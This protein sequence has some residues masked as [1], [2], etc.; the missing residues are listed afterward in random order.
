MSVKLFVTDLDGTLL[1]GGKTVSP[2]NIRAVREAVRAGVTV[3]I[4]TG[5]MYRAALPVAEALGVEVP[6][7]T[8]NGALI[9]S[10][11]GRVYYR[12]DIQPGTVRRVV[13]FCRKR[14]WHVQTYSRDELYFAEYD[15]YAR[16]YECDQQIR[17]HVVGW[18]GLLEHTEEVSKLLSITD[19]AEQTENRLHELREAFGREVSPV[20]SKAN[21][22][23]IIN[24]GVSKADG[25]RR[26]AETLG[27]AIADTMAIG[28]AENDLPM[29]K[30]AGRSVAMGNAV[31]AVR[32][33]CDYVTSECGQN[34]FAAAVYRYVLGRE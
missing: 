3:T 18:D 26:L 6:I 15:D 9:R 8:Y 19:G 25:V 12:S 21:Y 10:T 29:L 17:G 22:A 32:E 20:R 11:S 34:G 30:A 28:D 13:E 5:R 23:E 33:A 2:E 16:A 1:P 7:I 31:P 24:P 4:A 27:I 14:G